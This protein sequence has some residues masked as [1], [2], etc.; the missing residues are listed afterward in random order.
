MYITATQQDSTHMSKLIMLVTIMCKHIQPMLLALTGWWALTW[1]VGIVK[2]AAAARNHHECGPTGGNITKNA[3]LARKGE[4]GAK[5][6]SES[7][8]KTA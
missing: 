8:R 5:Q 2:A 3:N 6:A 4:L 1:S 7:F